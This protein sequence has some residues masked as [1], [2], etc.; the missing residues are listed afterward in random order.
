[1]N[2]SDMEHA[3]E[4]IKEFHNRPAKRQRKHRAWW[5]HHL[6]F[7][8]AESYTNVP[9]QV[10]SEIKGQNFKT[11]KRLHHKHSDKK[12]VVKWHGQMELSCVSPN[13]NQTP[14]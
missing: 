9:H 2:E 6:S 14:T 11:S 1:V 7:S 10:A 8:G 3:Q 13:Q 4:A 12:G 5:G